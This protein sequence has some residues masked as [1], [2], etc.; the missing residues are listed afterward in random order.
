MKLIL[1]NYEVN[2]LKCYTC[3]AE[4][5]EKCH[6][7]R[8]SQGGEE[9][10]TTWFGKETQCADTDTHCMTARTRMKANLLHI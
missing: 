3:T 6:Y 10:D 1:G 8:S 4:D 2:G 7:A 5:A 9:E